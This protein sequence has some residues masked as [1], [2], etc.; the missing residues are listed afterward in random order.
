MLICFPYIYYKLI[1]IIH[2]KQLFTIF[3]INLIIKVL[4]RLR[5]QKTQNSGHYKIQKGTPHDLCWICI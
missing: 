1:L 4:Q 2:D 3:N 5:D